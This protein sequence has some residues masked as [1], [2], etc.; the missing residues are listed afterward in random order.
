MTV[1]E[2]LSL[3]QPMED[4]TKSSF[5]K[6]TLGSVFWVGRHVVHHVF[7]LHGYIREVEIPTRML[8]I[9]VWRYVVLC[10]SPGSL[11]ISTSHV[12]YVDW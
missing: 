10:V 5:G 12:G 7:A 1:K 4:H 8:I 9:N 2:S 3:L 11:T 6:D